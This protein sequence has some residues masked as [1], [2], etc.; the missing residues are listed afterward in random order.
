MGTSMELGALTIPRVVT[1]M[2][3]SAMGNLTLN[4][5]FLTITLITTVGILLALQRGKI[6]V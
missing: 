3:T 5:R 2:E 1:Y 4:A 6:R